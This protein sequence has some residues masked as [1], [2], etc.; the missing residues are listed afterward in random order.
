MTKEQERARAKRRYERQQ[1]R[2]AKKAAE[3]KR[4]RQAAI[5]T[6][7]IIGMVALFIVIA[8]S[9]GGGTSTAG[10]SSSTTSASV[11]PS[12]GALAAGCHAPPGVPGN[13]AQLSKP[14]AG[15]IKAVTG[16]TIRARI[17]TNCGDIVIDLDGAKAPQAVASFLQLSRNGYW[18]NAPCHRLTTKGIF[19]L[20]CGDPTGTSQGT[21]G[22]SFG[23]ENTPK[24]DLYKRGVLAMARPGNNAE[25]N[26]GQYFIVYQDSTI[27]A[28][29]AGGYTV[30]G[31]V[32]SGLDIVDEIA[33]GGVVGG[34]VDGSPIFPISTLSITTETKD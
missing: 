10:Q 8:K 32:T 22:Y 27:P 9:V 31:T 21:P 26:G 20:Q 34:E 12:A 30:F 3:A 6:A 16:K 11:E 1:V 28:D 5:V 18:Q 17:T 15:D 33:A 2:E 14:S 24:D 29:D 25:G 7:V 19:V 23:L 4:T 13:T